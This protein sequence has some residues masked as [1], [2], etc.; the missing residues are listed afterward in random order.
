MEYIAV[1]DI[2]AVCEH[3]IKV[4]DDRDMIQGT[5]QLQ[6]I[7]LNHVVRSAAKEYII[8]NASINAVLDLMEL[9][10]SD[11]SKLQVSLETAYYA[12]RNN[13]SRS[14]ANIIDIPS[15]EDK[16]GQIEGCLNIVD[17]SSHN[18][19]Y[20]DHCHRSGAVKKMYNK[21][22]KDKYSR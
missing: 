14:G 18:A 13:L 16:Q 21:R 20:C 22:H 1:K 19:K 9:Q 4:L 12:L 15:L 10:R 3:I 17:L 7:A 5:V 6:G 8:E 11:L 2:N